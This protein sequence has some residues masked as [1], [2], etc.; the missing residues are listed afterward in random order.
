MRSEKSRMA[1]TYLRKL[2]A[3]KVH[4]RLSY[5]IEFREGVNILHGSNGAGKTT[6]LHIINNAL[7]GDFRSFAS[8]GF[9]TIRLTLSDHLELILKRTEHQ[10]NVKLD[11]V[12]LDHFNTLKAQKARSDPDNEIEFNDIAESLPG[13][14]YFPAFRSILEAGFFFEAPFARRSSE[15]YEM[16]F[17]FSQT[18]GKR[19]YF[20]RHITSQIFGSFV[21]VINFPSLVDIEKRLSLEYDKASAEVARVDRDLLTTIF[22][23]V[24]EQILL[25]PSSVKEDMKNT[26]QSI[27]EIEQLILKLQ[28][29][30]Q[31]G[32]QHYSRIRELL[33]R[34][35]VSHGQGFEVILDIYRESLATR[36][37]AQEDSFA[38][39]ARYIESVNDFLQGKVMELRPTDRRSPRE[40]ALRIR[41]QDGQEAPI[42]SLSSGERQIVTLLYAATHMSDQKVVLIDEPELSLHVDWQREL[43]P[44]M[45]KQLGSRQIIA[46]THS[47]IIGSEFTD[48]MIE[49]Q[50]TE[51]PWH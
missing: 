7:S 21:P 4:G 33:H 1:D 34:S 43:L 2:E 3:V 19:G 17:F 51:A 23:K 14:F 41:F 16:H 25:N 38:G 9:D 39:L 30:F 35:D 28:T 44:R 27:K 6:L 50:P 46:C 31:F 11:G 12:V 42:K 10:I 40:N 20:N 22:V 8:L 24:F 47:P 49:V 36:V 48:G 26:E 15:D 32:E 37:K 18:R 5:S 13:S 45:Q 29:E